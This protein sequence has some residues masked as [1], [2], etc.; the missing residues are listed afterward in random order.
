VGAGEDD[1]DAEPGRHLGDRC[2]VA[3]RADGY[4][5]GPAGAGGVLEAATVLDVGN[6]KQAVAFVCGQITD[7]AEPDAGDAMKLAQRGGAGLRPDR[8]VDVDETRIARQGSIE[9]E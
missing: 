6:R 4:E 9:A 3:L 2:S 7:Q 8:A 5:K 1:G